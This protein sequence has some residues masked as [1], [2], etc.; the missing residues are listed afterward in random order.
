M[1]S[2]PSRVNLYGGF[3]STGNPEFAD[4]D[5]D[6]H[7]TILD[8]ANTAAPILKYSGSTSVELDGFTLTNG[9]GGNAELAG[10]IRVD[11]GSDIK[12]RNCRF[13]KN[14]TTQAGAGIL[15]DSSSIEIERCTFEDNVA[16]R[17]SG[18]I[19]LRNSI[20]VIAD[21]SFRRNLS[22]D[23][24]G[25]LSSDGGKLTVEGCSFEENEARIGGAV[26]LQGI[27]A[28]ISNTLFLKNYGGRTGGAISI[29][30]LTVAVRNCTFVQNIV[31]DDT[32][33]H[34]GGVHVDGV[35]QIDIMNN[36]FVGSNGHAISNKDPLGS[37]SSVLNNLFYDNFDGVYSHVYSASIS[38]AATLNSTVAE[39]SGNIE[40]DPNF[41]SPDRMDFHL[42]LTS[43]AIDTGSSTNAASTDFENESRPFEV[44]SVGV[45]GS[46]VAFDI[47][48]DECV[49][50]DG[51]GL[52]DYWENEKG[53]DSGSNSGNDGAS[54]DP[55]NDSIT[56][57]DEF[58]LYDTNPLLAD[59]DGDG[60]DDDDEINTH[61][62]D[63]AAYDTD[64]D[65]ISDGD[66]NTNGTD[67][68]IKAAVY[69]S[70]SG[71]NSTGISW[72]TALHSM[73]AAISQAGSTSRD[74]W[75][76]TGTYSVASTI[77][78]PDGVNLYG[79][80]PDSG[81]PDFAQ[82][83]PDSSPTSLDGENTAAPILTYTG[84]IELEIDGVTF[85]N[86]DGEY[87]GAISLLD[88][89]ILTIR[90]STFLDNFASKVG[91][92]IY[93][94]A[95]DLTIED[96]IFENNHAKEGG[97]IQLSRATARI[98]GT[99]FRGNI[100]DFQGGGIYGY[101]SP[102]SVQRC[103]FEKNDS[104]R[105]GG[106]SV[107]SGSEFSVSNSL[108]RA[109]FGGFGGGGI[110]FDS[111][112]GIIVT[113]STFVDNDAWDAGGGIFMSPTYLPTGSI[114]NNIFANNAEHAIWEL[115]SGDDPAIENNLFFNNPEGHFFD[116]GVTSI[117]SATDL[118]TLVPEAS[119]NV[120]MDPLFGS[121]YH[122]RSTS[123][124]IDAGTTT[125]ASL[126]DFDGEARP[127]DVASVG[128]NGVGV[129]YDIGYDEFLD[130][131][132]DG[133]P[134]YWEIQYGL[135]EESNVGDDGPSGDLDEDGLTN[136]EEYEDYNTDPFDSDT[137]GDGL[138]DDDEVNSHGTDPNRADTDSDGLDDYEK[139]IHHG[140]DPNDD[141]SDGDELTD[142]DELFT[143]GTN[144][145]NEDSDGD[146]LNDGEEITFFASDP[147][148]FEVWLD[149][150]WNGTE[151]GTPFEPYITLPNA[152]E[153]VPSGETIL[154][155]GHS[156]IASTSW[157][158]QIDKRCRLD[159]HEGS[160]G[161]GN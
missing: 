7:V 161:I 107:R 159:A 29:H 52:P 95:A 15:V 143:Y 82:R 153:N 148:L 152:I 81:D 53:L 44:S 37:S 160:I 126:T 18:A 28:D 108:F 138:N 80:F 155:N 94:N 79:G 100:G 98:A 134:D 54:G 55:D 67:P 125:N 46:G 154:I 13:L 30:S 14:N 101:D 2:I 137:D 66:E 9:A 121:D 32:D 135:D 117:A 90:N 12:I 146:G 92:G 68:L 26:Y 59:S 34:G 132:E 127:V 73:S 113:H 74:V 38:T 35:L 115:N 1:T 64:G 3:S 33:S 112:Y 36:I 48:M 147:N 17:G 19:S 77:T 141:D 123:P 145:N 130:T 89:A 20:G 57:T 99:T 76:A 157:T 131:D 71:D 58:F 106:L 42:R 61:F 50:T 140:T 118:N 39:A 93:V 4:R 133:L 149:F 10:G 11:S 27:I 51:D 41:L 22:D 47:G 96:C 116:D 65:S 144:P 25:A 21:S 120:E 158:G 103:V 91:A 88:R 110:F 129:A 102:L 151:S 62:T 156:P 136:L 86:A 6:L 8:G 128:I 45:D 49:D 23:N 109:N 119:G 104:D 70:A 105:G 75:I 60:L 83:D 16:E 114:T 78:V 40:G 69:V 124:A 87:G 5:P 84:R 142:Y 63:P 43:P 85:K 24:G 122:F 150:A 97:G 139:I 111:Q 31:D 56:N 72:A